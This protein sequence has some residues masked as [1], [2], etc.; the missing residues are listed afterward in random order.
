[1]AFEEDHS[2]QCMRVKYEDLVTN[3]CKV[4][5]I[6]FT[7]LDV[8]WDEDILGD[9]FKVHHDDGPGDEKA[10]YTNRIKS[11]TIGRGTAIP[12]ERIHKPYLSRINC[13][14]EK[15]GYWTVENFYEIY[16]EKIAL[17]PSLDVSGTFFY[18]KVEGLEHFL[19]KAS[20]D[21]SALNG[22]CK[23]VVTGS[24]GGKWICGPNTPNVRAAEK[25]EEVS[26]MI[27]VTLETLMNILNHTENP[28]DVF[29]EGKIQV[30]G[31]L[32]TAEHFGRILLSL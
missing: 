15:L 17:S 12:Y 27:V 32:A 16:C 3:P 20:K 25:D 29:N 18:K 24:N 13:T 31:E 30:V 6:M 2:D 23:L 14:Q 11:D 1:M 10:Q 19:I 26:C 21:F 9:V 4:L 7:F 8:E 28:M 22:E 5:E